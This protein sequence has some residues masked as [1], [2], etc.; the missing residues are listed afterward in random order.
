MKKLYAEQKHTLYEL[1]E[2]IG[3]SHFS[4]YN[5]IGKPEKIKN[6]KY[7]MLMAIA[8]AEDIDAEV[9]QEKMLEYATQEEKDE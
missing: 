5:F 3:V 2:I 1:Q 6:I 9:L 8:K 4:L 7:N